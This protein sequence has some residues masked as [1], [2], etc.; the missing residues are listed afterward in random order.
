MNVKKFHCTFSLEHKQ[1]KEDVGYHGTVIKT[2][3]KNDALKF[4]QRVY[5]EYNVKVLYIVKV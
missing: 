1:N 3:H 2:N 4:L 5:P